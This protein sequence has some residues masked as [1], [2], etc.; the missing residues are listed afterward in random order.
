MT[1]TF[2]IGV[3]IVN[4]DDDIIGKRS[5]MNMMKR[6]RERV[7]ASYMFVY[8]NN[9]TKQPFYCMKVLCSICQKP[10]TKYSL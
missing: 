9:D 3:A 6:K 5:T 4:E 10:L 2:S 1:T 8:A 7:R